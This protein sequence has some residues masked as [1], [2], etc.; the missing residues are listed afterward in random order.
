[1]RQ[2]SLIDATVVESASAFSILLKSKQA[3]RSAGHNSII[4]FHSYMPHFGLDSSSVSH[5]Y[6]PNNPSRILFTFG[7]IRLVGSLQ[8]M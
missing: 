3:M 7:R 5:F 4:A 2:L 6:C 8:I 1:M